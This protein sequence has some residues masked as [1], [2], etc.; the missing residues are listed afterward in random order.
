M[1]KDSEFRTKKLSEKEK[2]ESGLRGTPLPYSVKIVVEGEEKAGKELKKLMEAASVLLVNKDK[3][4]D[5]LLGIELRCRTDQNTAVKLLQAQCYYEGAAEFSLDEN[6]KP[7]AI[8]LTL[9]PGIRYHLGRASVTYDPKPYVPKSFTERYR[10]YGLFGTDREDLPPPSFPT[11][12][13]GVKVGEPITADDMLSAVEAF[14]KTFHDKGYPLAKVKDSVYTLNTE[15]KQL[16]AEIVVETGPAAYF[17]ELRVHGN[18]DVTSKYIK[19]WV[20]WKKG[21]DPFDLDQLEDFANDLRHSALFRTVEAK[22][23]PSDLTVDEHGVAT[24]PIDLT[25]KEAL[26]RTVSA[27]A[28][29]DT[30]T[31]AGVE[32]GWEHNNLFHNG[33]KFTVRAPIAT[34]EQAIKF[35]FEKP[36]FYKREQK[37]LANAAL[38]HENTQ[39]Y[40]LTGGKFDTGL[41]RRLTKFFWGGAGVFYEGGVLKDNIHNQKT[42]SAYGPQFFIRHD[43]RDDK[44]NPTR[45]ATAKWMVKP[46]AGFFSENFTALAQTLSGTYYYAPFKDNDGRKS[47]K[48]VLAAKAEG[49][50]LLGPKRSILPSSMRYYTGGAGSVRGYVYQSIGPRDKSDDPSGGRS[51]QLVNLEARFKV[52]KDVGIVPFIDGGMVYTDPVPRIIGEMNWGAGLGL[53]YFTPIGPLRFDVATPLNPIEGEPP[54]QIYISI[55]QAF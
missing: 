55:G 39:A 49:G 7:I 2:E 37:L 17:G 51:Y 41:E 48:L 26:F 28:Y 33:E 32:L 10:T 14:P 54:V 45:G 30:A 11:T 43:S 3:A 19:S 25:V 34:Q 52:T 20:P 44:L 40:E 35:T 13:P 15:L 27:R 1:S 36:N 21:S 23:A 47:D 24:L 29:Y 12:L 50:S 16:N 18:K 53:R 4:P 9:K 31:G 38:I 22:A 6:A 42:F 5:S 8:V 46:F